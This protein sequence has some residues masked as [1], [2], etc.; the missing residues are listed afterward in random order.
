[1]IARRI[2]LSLIAA[3]ALLYFALALPRQR[4]AGAAAN[5]QRRARADLQQARAEAA[6][7]Q[8]HRQEGARLL[9]ALAQASPNSTL[10]QIRRR[11]LQ[12]IAVAHVSDVRL[13]VT[14]RQGATPPSVRV[15]AQGPFL[16]LV[17]LASRF[18]PDHG[19]VLGEV[20]LTAA[21]DREQGAA[22]LELAA[23]VPGGGQ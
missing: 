21:R 17:S 20:R 1:M 7:V 6:A 16:D 15:H 19:F 10:P 14:G 11:A 3:A 13:T 4:A 23:L 8:R 2:A 9:A 22:T 18:D 5:D 12:I